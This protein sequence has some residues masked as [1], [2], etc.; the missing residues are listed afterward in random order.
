MNGFPITNV[1]AGNTA[2]SVATLAQAMPIGAVIDYAGAVAPAG[3]VFCDGRALSRTTYVSLFN[4]LGTTYGAGDGFTFNVPDLRG[5]TVA[6]MDPGNVTGRLNNSGGMN[7]AMLGSAGGAQS[8]Q[9]AISDLPSFTPSGTVGTSIAH[10]ALST[11]SVG[12]TLVGLGP[13]GV[14][15][16]WM[17]IDGNTPSGASIT[18][19]STFVGNQIGNN[20]FHNNVQPTFILNKIIR[21]SYDV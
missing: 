6:G 8:Q 10:N 16:T 1:V 20:G 4:I 17:I 12:A 18:A 21:V 11:V 19:V 14:N 5:R 3:W 15:H 7:G 2:S 13:G 9:L